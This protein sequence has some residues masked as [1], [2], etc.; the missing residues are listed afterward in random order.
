MNETNRYIGSKEALTI[1]NKCQTC[2]KS[3]GEF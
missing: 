2:D 3:D 1:V